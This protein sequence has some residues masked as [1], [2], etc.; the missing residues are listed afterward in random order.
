MKR[1]GVHPTWATRPL[2]T[3]SIETPAESLE[4]PVEALVYTTDCGLL[5][6]PDKQE[7]SM[8]PAGCTA[9]VA[10]ICGFY[11]DP[12]RGSRYSF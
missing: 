8:N 6:Q 5:K 10:K 12:C 1:Y 3:D 4:I 7:L 2:G 9:L 11:G